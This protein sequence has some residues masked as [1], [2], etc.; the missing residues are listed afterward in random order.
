MLLQENGGERGLL[1]AEVYKVSQEAEQGSPMLF[2]EP[3]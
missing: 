3:N 2:S 1:A